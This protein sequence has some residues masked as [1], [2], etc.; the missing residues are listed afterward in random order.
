MADS[1]ACGQRRE[2]VGGEQQHH[3]PRPRRPRRRSSGCGRPPGRWP[4]SWRGC[5][6]PPSRRTPRRA[7]P[8]TPLAISS[9]SSRRSS[10][11]W[12]KVRAAASPSAMPTAAM[13]RPPVT[14]A[15]RS[16]SVDM[17]SQCS[18]ARAARTARRRPRG[19]RTTTGRATWETTM[20]PTSTIRAQG[21]RGAR[22]WP[23]NSTTSATTATPKAHRAAP[24]ARS[25]DQGQQPVEQAPRPGGSRPR[26]P[27]ISPTTISTTR[28][29]T[30]PVMIGSL[31]KRATQPTLTSPATSRSRRR[32]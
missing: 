15:P 14:R 22:R 18:S 6:P 2:Q 20:P 3:A 13:A 31:R 10:L 32:P 16:P 24:A 29:V 25:R 1:T 23:P 19:R 11:A 28:P 30:K 7:R 4:R 9:V 17:P 26:R 5:H 27:G 12:A 21:T 8:P